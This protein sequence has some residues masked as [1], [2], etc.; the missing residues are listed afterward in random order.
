MRKMQLYFVMPKILLLLIFQSF[1]TSQI[2]GSDHC[3][4]Q[5]RF[6]SYL[7]AAVDLINKAKTY[8]PENLTSNADPTVTQEKTN[9]SI[10]CEKVLHSCQNRNI[11]VQTIP[12]EETY[13]PMDC[14]EV[15]RSGHNRSGV[16]TIWP[17][18]RLTDG[19]VL[20]VY[21]DMDTDDGGWTVIQRRGNFNRTISF[22]FQDWSAYKN[23]F[24][25]VQEDFWLGNDNI[26][27]L[28]NQ[29]EYSIRFDLKSKKGKK[30]YAVYNVFWIDDEGNSMTKQHANQKF[31]TKDQDNDASVD[32]CAQA[33]KGGWWYG[34][35]GHVN[36]NGL[37]R[38]EVYS[39]DGI[40]WN[41]FGGPSESLEAAEMKIR[42]MNFK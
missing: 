11:T 21:C 30:R 41:L 12:L 5:G 39:V 19:K 2:L 27:A 8:I 25:N 16:Y 6:E 28:T 33:Y 42:P 37:Y 32:N 31:S 36:L 26:F 35:C 3:N 38:K 34:N 24:G 4:Y 23:G 9:L 18:N 1:C 22:F 7:D 20:D 15:L 13:H 40:F 10:E 17:R 14:D 29:R